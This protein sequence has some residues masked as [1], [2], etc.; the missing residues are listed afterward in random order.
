MSIKRRLE[1]LERGNGTQAEAWL[2]DLLEEL[3]TARSE[4]REPAPRLPTLKEN[5]DVVVMMRKFGI[6]T[7]IDSG[8]HQW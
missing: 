2:M 5:T 7:V 1:A 3:V 4:G 6:N 8:E